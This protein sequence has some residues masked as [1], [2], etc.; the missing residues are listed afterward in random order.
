LVF[1]RLPIA[2]DWSVRDLLIERERFMNLQGSITEL[3]DT[4]IRLYNELQQRFSEN[5]IVRD[6]WS[7]MAQDITQQKYSIS[8]LP[9]SFWTQLKD[10]Q[11]KFHKE[12]S[13]ARHQVI[14]KKEDLSLVNC[15]EHA[16]LYEEPATLKVY[17]PIIRRLRENWT[18]RSLD[19]YIMV[20]AHLARITRVTQ[21]F[22]GDP[23]IIQRSHMLLQQFEKEV[24]EQHVVLEHRPPKA[25]PIQ[26][27]QVQ[28]TEKPAA[29]PQPQKK[30]PAKK[31][32][33]LPKHADKHHGRAKPLV[34]KIGI[35]RRRAHR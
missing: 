3:Q 9:H 29:K 28:V 19:F 14:D 30:A 22:A 6:L 34:E 7:A 35:Q 2:T 12:I 32:P 10:E 24:Q 27:L 8:A 5:Q 4:I 20:K 18:D 26:D 1:E 15:F 16:F 11:D 23:R 25:R 31:K 13:A 17:V 21:S 33:S